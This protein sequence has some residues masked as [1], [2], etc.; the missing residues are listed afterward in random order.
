M[1][2]QEQVPV[3]FLDESV[4]KGGVEYPESG[5]ILIHKFGAEI[6]QP[7]AEGLAPVT[8]IVKLLYPYKGFPSPQSVTANN[9]AKRLLIGFIEFFSSKPLLPFLALFGL[10]PFK[11]K[12]KVS[13][14][15]LRW[16]VRTGESIL[17]PY[18]L[19]DIRYTECAKGLR[20][21][22]Q[23]FMR[24]IGI[25]DEWRERFAL[26]FATLIEYDT[27]YRLRIQ[28]I[29]SETDKNQLLVNPRKELQ[30]LCD[31]I[32]KRNANPLTAEKFTK[33]AK[34]LSWI[35]VL[36]RIKRAFRCAVLE[37]DIKLMQMDEAD[38]YH[39]LNLD[40]YDFEG[41]SIEERRA[42]YER[43]HNGNPPK[44]VYINPF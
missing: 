3:F 28:D 31:I 37:T 11:Y 41:R 38:R 1:I 36:P 4:Y 44:P 14:R 35:L 26:I 9:I 40:K 39:C 25:K 23:S 16:Y 19:E 33:T 20:Q 22:T 21:F 5:G 43:L 18:F 27:A 42:E 30:R 17:M 15:W 10:L 2:T 24:A 6:G 8:N 34:L 13:E 32:I 7:N 29:M 12:L